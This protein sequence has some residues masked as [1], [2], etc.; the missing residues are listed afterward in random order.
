MNWQWDDET[1]EPTRLVGFDMSEPTAHNQ[2]K[3]EAIRSIRQKVRPAGTA[4]YLAAP[5]AAAADY[6]GGD[7]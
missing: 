2:G 1:N 7:W 4:A 3:P 6:G 5:A